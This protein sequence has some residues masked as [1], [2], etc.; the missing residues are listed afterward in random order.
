MA[1]EDGVTTLLAGDG[2]D[3]LFGGNSRYAKQRV[4]GW[5]GQVPGIA[6]KHLLEPILTSKRR[7]IV[8]ADPQGRQLCRAGQ[9]A[10]ARPAADVQPDHAPGSGRSADARHDGAD[11]YHRCRCNCNAPSGTC[12]PTAMQLN[13][14]LAFDWRFTLAESDLPKVRGATSLAGLEVGFPMLDDQLLTFSLTSA[15]RTTSSRG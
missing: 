9:G 6:Q 14:E 15:R 1:R 12:R 11:R 4:F 3:E 2:G 8:L 5:Y 7:V 10:D 13:R